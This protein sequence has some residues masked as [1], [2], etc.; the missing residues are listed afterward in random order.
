MKKYPLIGWRE[1]FNQPIQSNQSNKTAQKLNPDMILMDLTNEKHLE[2]ATKFIN[3]H[4]DFDKVNQKRVWTQ[5]EL[6]FYFMAPNKKYVMVAKLNKHKV[7]VGLIAGHERN[8]QVENKLHKFIET[9]FIITHQ[10]AR[11]FFISDKLLTAYKKTCESLGF[12]LSIFF[13][14]KK[15]V[16]PL[17]TTKTYYYSYQKNKELPDTISE[18][19]LGTNKFSLLEEKHVKDCYQLFQINKEI[20]SV[21]VDYT[22]DEFKREFYQSPNVNTYTL[23]NTDNEVID[24]I[25][26]ILYKVIGKDDKKTTNCKLYYYTSSQETL[27]Q[28]IYNLMVTLKTANVDLLYANCNMNYEDYLNDLMIDTYVEDRY[29]YI[30]NLSLNEYIPKQLAILNH[31]FY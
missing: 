20:Y 13:N 30:Y 22:F 2:L 5:N 10:S 24:F 23:V 28:M 18:L 12:E 21:T 15:F 8:Y 31:P 26:C 9:D 11:K 3:Q 17:A 4:S 19:T 6:K 29:L 16:A 1:K 14:N 27:Y 7:I 25:S